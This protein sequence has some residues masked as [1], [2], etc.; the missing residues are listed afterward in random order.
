MRFPSQEELISD[1]SNTYARATLFRKGWELRPV[2]QFG[3]HE[4][5]ILHPLYPRPGQNRIDV[6]DVTDFDDN[7]QG[8]SIF[9]LHEPWS[10]DRP[11]AFVKFT[12]HGTAVLIAH[13]SGDLSDYINPSTAVLPF[14][15]VPPTRQ[16]MIET[17][18]DLDRELE[19]TGLRWGAPVE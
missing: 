4:Y 3:A 12:E 13:P 14:R 16:D 17:Q 6:V 15:V 19:D 8:L 9:R 2:V 18:D 7:D 5:I 1:A 10:E 11:E